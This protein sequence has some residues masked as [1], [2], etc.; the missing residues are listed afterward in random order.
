M[1][2]VTSTEA[3]ARDWH[4]TYH[5]NKQIVCKADSYQ[6]W[7][8]LGRQVEPSIARTANLLAAIVL[9]MGS[10]AMQISLYSDCQRGRE[11]IEPPACIHWARQDNGLIGVPRW[12]EASSV[13]R[14]CHRTHPALPTQMGYYVDFIGGNPSLLT[15]LS[16]SDGLVFSS[17]P[18]RLQ[19]KIRLLFPIQ[20]PYL[21]HCFKVF[22]CFFFFN[23]LTGFPT[24]CYR[25]PWFWS[26]RFS[27]PRLFE[28]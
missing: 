15:V 4:S 13:K 17:P 25:S 14:S 7:S 2:V 10:C 18:P 28:G 22:S 3:G 9:T 23:V 21:V 11:S 16:V 12:Q 26:G 24:K 6:V 20:I 1:L 27:L 19:L 8:S 5:W